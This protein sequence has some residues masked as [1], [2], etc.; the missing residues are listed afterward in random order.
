MMGW[1]RHIAR[2]D[3][4]QN[5]YIIVVVKSEKKKLRIKYIRQWEDNIKVDRKVIVLE[6][7]VWTHLAKDKNRWRALV[8][9]VINLLVP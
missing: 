7:V 3:E 9:R 4:I 1:A 5:A 6:C 2:M 8:S